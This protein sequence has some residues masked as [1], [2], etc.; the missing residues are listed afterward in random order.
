MSISSL[1]EITARVEPPR[2][3][4]VEAPL[5]YP[6]GKPCNATLQKQIM[7]AAFALLSRRV[8]DPLIVAFNERS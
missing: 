2:V 7:L 8:S 1:L 5:G 3:L 6:L 4:A